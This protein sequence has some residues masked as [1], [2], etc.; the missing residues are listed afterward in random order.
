MKKIKIVLDTNV[1]YAGLYSSLGA[2]HKILRLIHEGRLVPVLSATLLFEYEEIL[3]RNQEILQLSTQ[4]IDIVL[5]N[6]C[7]RAELQKIHFL[8]RPY[9]KDAKDDHVLE[10]AVASATQTIVT[11]NLKDF[12][13]IEKF[14]IQAI[15]PGKILEKIL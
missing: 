4:Q 15:P 7:L 9:L 8:W 1:L 6:L 14:G 2:S 10:V 12:V 11:F 3:L 5:D 13:G